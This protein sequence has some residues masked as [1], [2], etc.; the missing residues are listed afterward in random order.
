MH[1]VKV[2]ISNSISGEQLHAVLVL[3]PLTLLHLL[4]SFLL[5]HTLII[6]VFDLYL[7]HKPSTHDEL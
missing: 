7:N 2:F 5:S 1:Y 6:L 4:I 3:I